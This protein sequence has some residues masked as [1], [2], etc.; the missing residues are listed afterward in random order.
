MQNE[1]R[2]KNKKFLAAKYL[3]EEQIYLYVLKISYI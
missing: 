1:I 2:L 3:T